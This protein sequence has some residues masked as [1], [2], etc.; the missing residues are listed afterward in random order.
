[1]S[2]LLHNFSD[3][4]CLLSRHPSN[5]A[6]HGRP[7]ELRGCT[8]TVLL[9]LFVQGI[10]NSATFLFMFCKLFCSI[11]VLI[12]QNKREESPAHFPPNGE[13]VQLAN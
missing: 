4:A 6:W 8:F 13:N 1:M 3:L 11:V 2:L 10:L 7:L 5:I 9:V 12:N